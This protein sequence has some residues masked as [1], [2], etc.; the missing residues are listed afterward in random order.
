MPTALTVFSTFVEAGKDSH[1]LAVK[2]TVLPMIG[3]G[4]GSPDCF[5]INELLEL[6]HGTHHDPSSRGHDREDTARILKLWH[7]PQLTDMPLL[8]FAKTF[9]M[10]IAGEA[11]QRNL[12][13]RRASADELKRTFPLD[14]VVQRLPHG[15]YDRRYGI[16]AGEIMGRAHPAMAEVLARHGYRGVLAYREELRRTSNL[17][18]ELGR[19]TDLTRL[20]IRPMRHDELERSWLKGITVDF[21]NVE[22]YAVTGRDK[23]D[24]EKHRVVRHAKH[25]GRLTVFDA[26]GFNHDTMHE[27]IGLAEYATTNPLRKSCI[28]ASVHDR[29]KPGLIGA[30]SPEVRAGWRRLVGLSN[31]AIIATKRRAQA[32]DPEA[33]VSD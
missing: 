3:I 8:D 13:S 27:A 21:T 30:N 10:I 18:Q 26:V 12:F 25:D 4:G 9:E 29:M 16:P 2:N 17:K 14:V 28:D 33:G 22:H 7:Y 24:A 5:V 15:P 32:I 19:M 6:V 1:A 20:Q 23:T 31:A 11:R